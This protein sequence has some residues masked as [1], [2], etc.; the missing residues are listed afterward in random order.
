VANRTLYR[1]YY[2]GVVLAAVGLLAWGTMGIGE[3]PWPALVVWVALMTLTEIAPIRLPGGG[4]ITVSSVLDYAGLLVFGPFL[5][6]WVD[7]FSAIAGRTLIK[8]PR[9]LHKTV[10][11]VALYVLTSIVAGHTYLWLGGEVGALSLPGDLPAVAAMGLAYFVVNTVGVSLVIALTSGESIWKVWAVNFRWT[12]F[13]LVAFVP[14]GCIA[15]FLYIELGYLGV[16]L[17]MFPVLLAR[18]SFKLYTEMRQD[19]IDFVETLT[20]VIEEVDPYTRD[21]SH[22]VAR[23]TRLIAREMGLPA[24]Q[25]ET[26]ATAALLHDLGKVSARTADIIESPDGLTNEQRRRIVQHPVIG[27]DIVSRIRVLRDAAE[28]VRAHHERV[29]GTGYPMRLRGE[30]IPLGARILMVADTLDAMTSDR[31]YRRALSLETA[32]DELQR[33]SGR[34]FDPDVVDAVARLHARGELPMLYVAKGT[35]PHADVE[36]DERRRGLA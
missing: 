14:F 3:V 12:I 28:F 20:R 1:I 15:A 9:P 26:I 2:V 27:A 4:V 13:H 6:A 25:V 10:F 34:Q 32:I 24:A 5:T 23:Y 17:F 36:D 16:V 7:I 11:N 19:F 18:F 21:H 35:E 31:P 30:E 8:S 22:R 29:D 33:G